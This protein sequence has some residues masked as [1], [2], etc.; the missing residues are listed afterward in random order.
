MR[1]VI[2]ILIV[3]CSTIAV[4]LLVR[5]LGLP[6]IKETLAQPCKVYKETIWMTFL[7][8]FASFIFSLCLLKLNKASFIQIFCLLLAQLVVVSLY[9]YVNYIEDDCISCFSYLTSECGLQHLK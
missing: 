7:A 3:L 4:C 8:V 5:D 2:N 1:L 9:A 6:D